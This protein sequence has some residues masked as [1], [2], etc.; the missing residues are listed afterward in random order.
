MHELSVAEA[1]ADAV[2]ARAGSRPATEA[3]VRIGYLRQVVPDALTFAWSMI[4]DGS[5]LDGCALV[6]EHVPATVACRACGAQTTLSIPVLVC[7]DCGTT[8]VELITGDE[9]LL[10]SIELAAGSRR[11][12]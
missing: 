2:S 7:G 9:F 4:T 1:I 10:V 6:V 11:V 8:D 12:P 3:R 5:A